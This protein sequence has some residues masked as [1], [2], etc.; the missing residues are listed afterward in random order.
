[1]TVLVKLAVKTIRTSEAD[2][3]LTLSEGLSIKGQIRE[4]NIPLPCRV[5]LFERLTGRL[6]D[7]VLTDVSGNYEFT[8]LTVNKFFVVAHHPENTFNAVIADLVVPK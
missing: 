5:R 2:G 7:D 1:M 6:I 8:H 3:I 4:L